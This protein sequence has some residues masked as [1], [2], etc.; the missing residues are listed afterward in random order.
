M[1]I[2]KVKFTMKNAGNT[3]RDGI[4]LKRKCGSKSKIEI[5]KD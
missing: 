4:K 3:L 2:K 5:R 1:K